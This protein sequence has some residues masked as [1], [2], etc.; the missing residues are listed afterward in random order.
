MPSIRPAEP[1]DIP[2]ITRIYAY[3]VRHGTASFELEPP[4]V[5]EI[6]RRYAALI[7][8]GFP[9]FVAEL[10]GTVRSMA[11]HLAADPKRRAHLAR[12]RIELPDEITALHG[13]PERALLIEDRRMR[14]ARC[15][16]G[17]RIFG[18]LACARIQLSDETCGVAE[19]CR[20]L[21][22]WLTAI[23]WSPPRSHF[24]TSCRWILPVVLRGKSST[25]IKRTSFGRL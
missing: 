16:I 20:Q 3:A 11:A 18:Y 8:G 12:L 23:Q 5:A 4:D 22:L 13:E 7:D 15:R 17:H 14:I 25:A 9:S 2:A 1:R 21:R 19:T 6:G 10:D 24:S